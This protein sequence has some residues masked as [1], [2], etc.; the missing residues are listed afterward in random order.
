MKNQGLEM[1]NDELNMDI[2]GTNIKNDGM[3][4]NDE[5]RK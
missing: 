2:K 5:G 3:Q 1:K 4:L